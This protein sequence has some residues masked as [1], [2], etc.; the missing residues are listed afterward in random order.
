MKKYLIIAVTSII[1]IQISSCS[2][3]TAIG[4]GEL[5]PGNKA[6][7][8][9]SCF[10]VVIKKPHSDSLEYERELPVEMLSYTERSNQYYSIGTAFAVSPTEMLTAYHVMSLDAWSGLFASTYIRN[11]EGEVFPIKEIL[12]YDN[13][14]DFVRFQVD[15]GIITEWLKLEKD[16]SL[17]EV[18]YSAGNAYGEGIIIRKGDLIGTVYEPVN[19]EWVDIKSSSD[20]NPG[21]SG[22]P[23]LNQKGRVIGIVVRKKDNISYS[24][25]I[26]EVMDFPEKLGRINSYMVYGF[27]LFPEKSQTRE[28][29]HRLELPMKEIEVRKSISSEYYQFYKRGIDELFLHYEDEIFPNGFSSLEALYSRRLGSFPQCV[30]K[31][32]DDLKWYISNLDKKSSS[33]GGGGI[34]N[35]ANV[36]DN[37]HFIKINKPRDLPLT[38]LYQ[39]PKTQLDL[40]LKGLNI[41]RAFADQS[42]RITSMGEPVNSELYSDR[43]N[44]KW[45]VNTWDIEYS[46]ESL[47]LFTMPN[48]RG[49]SGFFRIVPSSERRQW[50]VDF[51][52]LTDFIYISY[53]GKLKEWKEFLSFK[54]FLPDNFQDIELNYPGEAIEFKSSRVGFSLKSDLINYN[55]DVLLSLNYDFY[56]VNGEVIWDIRRVLVAEDRHDNYFVVYRNLKAEHDLPDTYKKHWEDVINRRH[57]YNSLVYTDEGRTNIGTVHPDSPGEEFAYTV[58]FAGEGRIEDDIMRIYFENLINGIEFYE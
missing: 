11:R 5:T 56:K 18:V 33:L 54:D 28:F 55:E 50:M 26:Q 53:S 19:G 43:Y 45:M 16:F 24:L 44:R 39:E 2:T 6:Q 40:L 30:Y 10:E 49:V 23:L 34:L 47:I 4:E 7:I 25:P 51:E 52:K 41:P 15:E 27:P 8:Y 3:L 12:Q 9:N 38:R 22:G 35:Y 13:R 48:P 32:K 42:I 46:D 58:Y 20:V 57:P 29:Y 1:L 21:N 14:R 36:V 17:N 37:I 31:F